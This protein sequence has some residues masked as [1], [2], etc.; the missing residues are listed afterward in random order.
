MGRTTPGALYG[1]PLRGV[2]ERAAA[3]ALIRASGP[4]ARGGC[5]KVVTNS[6][7]PLHWRPPDRPG[8]LS[9]LPPREPAWR[10]PGAARQRAMS[11]T[12]M[13]TSDPL[14]LVRYLD[15]VVVILAAPF[16]VLADG[17]V[18]GYV[19]GAAAWIFTRIVGAIVERH[20]RRLDYKAQIA[21][22]FGV[23]MARVWVVGIAI[24]VVGRTADREDGL[25]AAL[26]ALVAFTIYLATSLILRP[27]ERN[28]QRP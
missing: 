7:K 21:W 8:S 19:V 16:V 26:L 20:A 9:T 25:M 17:P 22:N 2:A 13:P 18:L 15:V 1:Y 27:S 5:H 24:L 12:T 11:S 4:S 6:Q 23:L 3:A 28:T 10:W 14:V